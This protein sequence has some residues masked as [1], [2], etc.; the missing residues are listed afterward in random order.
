ME[1]NQEDKKK[2]EISQEKDKSKEIPHEKEKEKEKSI[3]SEQE[4]PTKFE[5]KEDSSERSGSIRESGDSLNFNNRSGSFPKKITDRNSETDLDKIIEG[6]IEGRLNSVSIDTSEFDKNFRKSVNVSYI[7]N[8]YKGTGTCKSSSRLRRKSILK[9]IIDEKEKNSNF[10]DIIIAQLNEL[11]DNTLDYF[12]QLL[13]ELENKYVEYIEQIEEYIKKNEIKINKVFQQNIDDDEKILEYTENNIFQQ[14]ANVL[15][16][17]EDIINSFEGHANLLETF[18]EQP[19]VIKHKNPLEYFIINNSNNILNCWILNKIDYKKINVRSLESN[20]EL[21]ELYSKYLIKKKNTNFANI[22]ITQDEKGNLSMG[23]D[24]IK[25]NLKNLEKV[26]FNSVKSDDIRKSLIVNKEGKSDED[27]TAYK[28]KSFT[29]IKSDFPYSKFKIFTPSL[30]KIKIKKTSLPLSLSSFLDSFLYK[31]SFLKNLY[32]QKCLIDDEGLQQIF[33]Y[34]AEKPHFVENLQNISLIGNDITIVDMQYLIDKKIEFKKLE[35][36]DFSKNNIF[37]F[38]SDNFHVLKNLK[39]LDLTNNNLTNYNFFK[40]VKNNKNINCIL[41]LSGNMFLTNNKNNTNIYTNYLQSNLKNNNIKIKKLNLSFLFEKETIPDFLNLKLSPI[42][43]ISLTKLNLSYCALD[44]DNVCKFLKNN[45][46]LL[47][48]K[49]LNLSSNFM[50]LKFFKDIK[51]ADLS[52]EKLTCLDLSMNNINSLTM[53]EYQ[54]IE[55]FI[56]KYQNLKRIK[57]QDNI[58]LQELLVL[59]Q[60]ENEKVEEINKNL[61]NKEFKFIVETNNALMIEPLKEIFD[62]KD[63]EE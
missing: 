24:F 2:E 51:T 57:M 60:N 29:I 58:F 22:S 13:K 9:N 15:E 63:K 25:Q 11:K 48:L 27:I 44:N 59:F 38:V 23:A 34:L 40:D 56:N 8:L 21:S 16:I 55:I 31:S 36:L 32:L 20:K 61:I 26:K 28:L 50:T 62:I 14:I 45:F 3:I 43:K 47:N 33:H 1:I 12:A 5:S 52:L 54:D 7:S 41:L 39:I 30:K 53:D 46:G 6:K 10:R 17:H 35:V 19:D 4:N 37:D 18:L 49:V 42:V